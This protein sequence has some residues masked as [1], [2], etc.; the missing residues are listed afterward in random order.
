MKKLLFILFLLIGSFSYGQTVFTQTYV[1]RCT[2]DVK[3]VVANFTNGSATVAFYNKVRTFTYEEFLSGELQSWLTETYTWWNAL[4]PCSTATA[5][6]QQAQQV[7]Q[8]ATQAAQTA[9][10]AAANAAAAVPPPVSTPPPPATNTTNTNATS[11]TNTTG[12]TSQNT[13]GNTTSGNEQSSSGTSSG[14]TEGG[15]SSGGN[16]SEGS[17]NEGGQTSES[18]TE[19]TKS[20]TKSESDGGSSDENTETESKETEST[21]ENKEESKEEV[22]EEESKEEESSEE[23]EEE[24]SEEKEEEKKE[25]K[26]EK[27]E[28]K[29][30]KMLPIQLR[31]DLM[32]NQALLGNY[33]IVTSI[34]ATQ[35]SIFGDESYGAT[36]MIWSNLRQFSLNGS[37]TKVH[38]EKFDVSTLTHGDHTHYSKTSNVSVKDPIEPPT[39]KLSHITSAS[40]GY[41]N[42]FGNG[43]VMANMMKIKPTKYGT[44]GAGLNM[45]NMFGENT[46][47]MTM[48]GYN[49]LYT[50]QVMLNPRINYAPAFIWTQTPFVTRVEWERNDWNQNRLTATNQMRGQ[51]IH[52]MIILANSFTIQLTRRFSFNA[53]ATFIKSTDP[54]IPL[55]KSF[56][57]GAKL[58]F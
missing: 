8:N 56:M 53:G 48:I 26:K 7:A 20:E 30:S 2:G 6:T 24:N 10:S 28:K 19:D 52:G 51:R 27:K 38:M 9:Q 22:K 29:Q 13:S 50:N 35:S 54:N 11:G 16:T 4:S 18:K 55:I 42:N 23:K 49:V 39:P 58:P 33:D 15:T 43:A 36:M 44:F 34:G 3:V 37:Y 41:M 45:G 57:I 32:A 31:S 12:S 47:Q 14:G 17:S 21:E 5:E 25:E 46:Y 40:V 1:D